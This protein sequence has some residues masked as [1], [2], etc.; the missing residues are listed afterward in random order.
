MSKS[1]DHREYCIKN[2]QWVEKVREKSGFDLEE[3]RHGNTYYV[4]NNMGDVPYWEEVGCEAVRDIVFDDR[5]YGRFDEEY[6]KALMAME[7]KEDLEMGY[8]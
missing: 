7:R 6:E 4:R 3:Y 2:N 8:E 1:F 5:G